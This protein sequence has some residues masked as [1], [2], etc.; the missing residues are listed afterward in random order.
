MKNLYRTNGFGQK[1]INS[2]VFLTET[3]ICSIQFVS[4]VGL[5]EFGQKMII[6][7][8]FLINFFM[9]NYHFEQQFVLRRESRRL[10]FGRTAFRS[11]CV[12]NTFTIFQ[13]DV[14]GDKQLGAEAYS[15]VMIDTPNDMLSDHKYTAKTQSKQTLH[16]LRI[17]KRL[18]NRNQSLDTYPSSSPP[19]PQPQHK[20]VVVQKRQ[21]NWIFPDLI[22]EI[23][24]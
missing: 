14:E 12:T 10:T 5:N 24:T 15:Y 3:I 22:I 11:S 23:Q 16:K 13:M 21:K 9:T 7:E 18:S 8:V 2:E 6:A 17:K 4:T 1:N 20:C 19:P